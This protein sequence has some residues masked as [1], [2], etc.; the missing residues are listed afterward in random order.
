[1]GEEPGPKGACTGNGDHGAGKGLRLIPT[2]NVSDL[3]PNSL[4]LRRR[5]ELAEFVW[6]EGSSFPD[7]VPTVRRTLAVPCRAPSCCR[8]PVS[9]TALLQTHLPSRG[10]TWTG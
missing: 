1:M 10:S 7:V 2:V 3:R 6:W 4:S 5:L 9:S 8:I